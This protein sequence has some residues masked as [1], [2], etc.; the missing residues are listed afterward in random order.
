MF[1]PAEAAGG[2]TYTQ[3]IQRLMAL[4]GIKR[5]GAK[6][7]FK[8]YQRL[9]LVIRNPNAKELFIENHP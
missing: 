5:D 2:F 9:K 1:A 7:R 8:K 4:E 6:K 3:C